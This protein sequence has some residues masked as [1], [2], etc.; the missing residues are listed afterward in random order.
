MENEWIVSG[1]IFNNETEYKMALNDEKNIEY[2]STKIDFSNTK[3]I[4]HLYESLLK[5]KSF[6]TIVGFIFL[7][8]LYDI[9]K[10]DY[11]MQ[12]QEIQLLDINDY[13]GADLSKA[14]QNSGKKNKTVKLKIKNKDEIEKIKG[15]NRLLIAIICILVMAVFAMFYITMHSDT[16]TYNRAKNDVINEYEQ[17]NQQLTDRENEIAKK[18]KEIK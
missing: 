17:W 12:G 2:I 6:K 10:T 18:E 1:I 14:N 5:K 8:Q 16:L 15:T 13:I 3:M 4:T 7:K 9:I 11:S